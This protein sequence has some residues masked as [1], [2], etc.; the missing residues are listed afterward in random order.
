MQ[1]H[2][3]CRKGNPIF[4]DVEPSLEL[5]YFAPHF[6]QTFLYFQQVVYRI[7]LLHQRE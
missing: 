5:F 6:R 3:Y 1:Q 4:Q 2:S 7:G